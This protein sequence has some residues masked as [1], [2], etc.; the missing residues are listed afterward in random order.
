MLL[1]QEE[2]DKFATYLEISAK[3]GRGIIEQFE[4]LGPAHQ[5]MTEKLKVE[6]LAEEIVASKLRNTMDG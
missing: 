5:V 3:S 6:A 2:R 1:S 4:K